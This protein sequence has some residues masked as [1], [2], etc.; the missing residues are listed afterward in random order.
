MS[1]RSS[2]YASVAHPAD[3]GEHPNRFMPWVTV[4]LRVFWPP[5]ATNEEVNAALWQAINE[6]RM[7]LLQREA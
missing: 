4:D 5:K 6:V 2:A 1:Q 3:G 7:Q